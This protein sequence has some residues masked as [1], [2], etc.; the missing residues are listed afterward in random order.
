MKCPVLWCC[1]NS[2]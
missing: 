1:F 2:K